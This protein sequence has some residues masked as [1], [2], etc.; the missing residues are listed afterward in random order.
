MSYRVRS[1]EIS[2]DN[3]TTTTDGHRFAMGRRPSGR[4]CP[5][6]RVDKNHLRIHQRRPQPFIVT[7]TFI[8]Y[9]SLATEKASSQERK[10]FCKLA[11]MLVSPTSVYHSVESSAVY[12]GQLLRLGLS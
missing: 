10:P 4:S 11:L 8:S 6:G 1:Q 7:L 9:H 5:R 3:S 12:V 2:I